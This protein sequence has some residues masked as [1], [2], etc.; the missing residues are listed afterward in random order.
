VHLATEGEESKL[1]HVPQT[2]LFNETFSVQ[3]NKISTK[4]SCIV[5]PTNKH[6]SGLNLQTSYA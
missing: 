2:K 1:A 6:Q 3:I 4:P 5:T